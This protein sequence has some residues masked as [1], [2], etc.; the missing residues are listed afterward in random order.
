MKPIQSLTKIIREEIKTIDQKFRD[1]MISC[2]KTISRKDNHYDQIEFI[3]TIRKK[4][5]NISFVRT[6]IEPFYELRTFPY[7]KNEI[8]TLPII[9]TYTRIIAFDL[10]RLSV[11]SYP[12]HNIINHFSK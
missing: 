5:D 10:A 6:V 12:I 8:G 1:H 9:L 2:A 4:F 11:L 3:N 7:N